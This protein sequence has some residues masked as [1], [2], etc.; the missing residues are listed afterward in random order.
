MDALGTFEAQRPYV[1]GI[2]YRM[3]G[4]V[5]DAQDVVQETWLRWNRTLEAGQAVD[6]PR[7][8]L[9][10][11]VTRLSID[12]LR[13]RQARRED[14]VGPWLPEPLV[15]EA[16]GDPEADFALAESVRMAFLVV[17]ERL[18][19]VERAVFLLREV[20][21]YEY[22]EIARIVDRTA[23]NCRQIFARAKKHVQDGRPRLASDR[24]EENR[25]A[26]ELLRAVQT[27]DAAALESLLSADVVAWGDGGGK[28]TAARRPIVG[29]ALVTKFLIGIARLAPADVVIE[30]ARVNHL[31]GFIARSGGRVVSVLCLDVV[32]GRVAAIRAVVNPDKLTHFSA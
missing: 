10:R 23:V 28:A 1:F 6:M 20:F 31:P 5:S 7:A 29:R 3:L 19:P 13:D 30:R 2:A 27:G 17:L 22:D 24:N 18:S 12:R 11:I 32:D 4:T 26:D 16:D 25:V 8:F 9:A 15:I 14:Y 21:D